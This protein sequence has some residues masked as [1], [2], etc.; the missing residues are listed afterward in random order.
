MHRVARL[1]GAFTLVGPFNDNLYIALRLLFSVGIAKPGKIA[2]V[3]V[4]QVTLGGRYV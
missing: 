1:H 4:R 2:F 3:V